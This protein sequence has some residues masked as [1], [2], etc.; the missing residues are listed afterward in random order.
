V[1]I[2]RCVVRNLTGTA[3][4][5]TGASDTVEIVDTVISD[6]GSRGL[7]VNGAPRLLVRNVEVARSGNEGLRLENVGAATIENVAVSASGLNGSSGSNSGSRV[8]ASAGNAVRAT[9]DR[10]K[11]ADSDGPGVIFFITATDGSIVATI[12]D[13]VFTRSSLDAAANG[14][15]QA[16]ASTGTV[17]A[18][19]VA[20]VG[21]L[22]QANVSD[23]IQ[24]ASGTP[25]T[26]TVSRSTV[27]DNGR[28]AFQR[29]AARSTRPATTSSAATTVR[30]RRTRRAARSRH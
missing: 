19:H 6:S 1:R 8:N 24:A 3:I 14:A 20:I 15:I 22:I 26:V 13:S 9:F 5:A 27:V 29:G 10:V 2:E 11:V 17:G 30:R 18:L 12:R 4:A 25:V 23:G 28:L 21:T 7:D 16:V